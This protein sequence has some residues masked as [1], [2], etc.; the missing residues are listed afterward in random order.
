MKKLNFFE[1]QLLRQQ[2]KNEKNQKCY[3]EL[4]HLN[5]ILKINF[6]KGEEKYD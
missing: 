3:K 6:Q 1:K 4:N 5:K 2:I